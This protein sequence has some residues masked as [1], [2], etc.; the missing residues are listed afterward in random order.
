MSII[1]PDSSLLLNHFAGH[2]ICSLG[3][4][5]LPADV[6]DNESEEEDVRPIR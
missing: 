5:A 6:Q 3:P 1:S 2:G 4:R